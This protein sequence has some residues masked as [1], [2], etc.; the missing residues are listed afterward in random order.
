[1]SPTRWII[2]L[3]LLIALFTT[4]ALAEKGALVITSEPGGAKVYLNNQRKG[5]TPSLQGK[6]LLLEVPEGEYQVKGVLDDGLP[7]KGEMN[8]YV[9]AGAI[10]P[11]HLV[12]SGGIEMV[13][14]VAGCFQMG[15]PG[16][17]P[18]RDSDEGPQHRVCLPAFELGRHEVTF[19]EWDACVAAKGCSHKPEDKGWGRG[20]RPVI[21]V[22]WDDAQQYIQWLNRTSGKPY[23]LPSEAEWEYAARAGTSTP[24]STGHCIN[25]SQANYDGDY[26]YND[27]GA[28]TGTDL[29]K[30]QPVGSYP[31]NPWGLHD[32]HGNVWEWVEDCWNDN[33]QGAP[34]DGSAWRHGN[35]QRR[36][37]RGGSWNDYPWSLRSADRRRLGTG[38]RGNYLGFRLARTLTP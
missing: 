14:I 8:V 38:G 32:L 21:N 26:D 4:P 20:E 12:L 2:P 23:R 19:Q 11:V 33:Y 5:N 13:R 25:T 31:A 16:S 35:C 9:S 6:E 30:T 17:E 28:K 22:S 27:C 37:R 29:N 24:F 34:T 7:M 3:T 10:Q 15:S 1:M 18:G 36:V